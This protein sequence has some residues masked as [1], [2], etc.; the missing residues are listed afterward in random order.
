MKLD[1][2]ISLNKVIAEFQEILERKTYY[3]KEHLK[4]NEIGDSLSCLNSIV[5]LINLRSN[6]TG[7]SYKLLSDR[8]FKEL[9]KEIARKLRE[10]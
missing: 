5:D 8:Y 7:E 2:K 4:N 3:C 10:C 1:E 6:I 9:S